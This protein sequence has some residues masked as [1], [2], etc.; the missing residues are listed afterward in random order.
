MTRPLL[1]AI[2][3]TLALQPQRA[4][5]QVPTPD[6]TITDGDQPR[7]GRGWRKVQAPHFDVVFPLGLEADAQRVARTLEQLHAPLGQTM[8]SPPNRVTIVLQNESLLSNGYVALGPR[9]AVW[10]TT[11]PTFG[12]LAGTGDWLSLLATH[13]TRHVTQ[14]DRTDAGATHVARVLF[15]DLGWTL[16]S[17]LAVPSWMWEGDAV[18]TESAMSLS[19]RARLPEFLQEVKAL[20]LA[21]KLPGY[22]EAMLGSYNDFFPNEYPLGYLMTSYL[23]RHHGDTAVA[24]LFRNSAVS[25]MNPLAFQTAMR[26]AVGLTPPTLYAKVMQEAEETWR[27]EVTALP[28]TQAVRHSPETRV[29]TNFEYPQAMADGSVVALRRGF[30]NVREIVRVSGSDVVALAAAPTLGGIRAGGTL[31][32]WTEVVRDVRWGWHEDAEIKLLDLTNNHVRTVGERGRFA[33]PVP[34]PDGLRVAVVELPPGGGSAIVILDARSGERL[35]TITIPDGEHAMRPAWRPDGGALVFTRQGTMGKAL[36]VVDLATHDFRDIIA[37]GTEDVSDPVYGSRIVYFSSPLSGIDNVHAIDPST[38]ARFQV[39]SARIGAH[40]PSISGDNTRLLYTEYTITGTAVYEAVVDSS[41]WI[42]V[43]PAQT[44]EQLAEL[45]RQENFV[46][47]PAEVAAQSTTYPVKGLGFRDRYSVHSWSL[48]GAAEAQ[49]YGVSLASA[50]VFNTLASQLTML[51]NTREASG[52]VA[53]NVSYAGLFPIIDIGGRYGS[54]AGSYDPG[55]ESPT[56]I[57][58]WKENTVE[59]G[60]RVP[61]DFSRGNWARSAQF[62]VQGSMTKISG[63]SIAAANPPGNGLFAPLAFGAEFENRRATARRDLA[64]QAGQSLSLQWRS[65]PLGGDFHPRK[66]L[67][68]ST[69]YLPTPWPHHM[70]RLTGG[71]ENH[72]LDGGFGFATTLD[73][74]RGY[75]YR[76]A[77]RMTVATLDYALPIAYPDKAFGPV[78][79]IPRITAG[80]FA[81]YSVGSSATT[82]RTRNSAGVE[83]MAD[84]I[85]FTWEIFRFSAG[86]RVAY[87]SEDRRWGCAAGGGDSTLS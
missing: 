69:V 70:L 82:S 59:A 3:L 30:A 58:S 24:S 8:G 66:F 73:A 19:G 83:L 31:V 32:A 7:P 67:G 54:R 29:P 51:Y 71:Q 47:T 56:Q 35:D 41:T 63:L 78:A 15:G 44:N 74:P 77:P 50:D 38:G 40:A 21:G 20:A 39:T 27:K 23:R 48:A 6:V 65:A 62:G 87:T 11:P 43:K 13:E 76:F 52:G 9:R 33:F 37:H 1:L 75:S 2:V 45:V 22:Y 79:Y 17:H 46:L 61:L 72:D 18:V 28:V 57:L 42:G 14:T 5:C 81:D 84:V 55:N 25:A 86:V 36:T 34:S 60:V 80:V 68:T 85:P 16:M 10:I 53:A 49:E 64:P 4:A 12:G 26:S